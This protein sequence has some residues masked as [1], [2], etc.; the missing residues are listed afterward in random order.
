MFERRGNF[1]SV[2]EVVLK[3]TGLSEDELLCPVEEPEIYNL[4]KAVEKIKSHLSNHP[5]CMVWIVGDYDSDGINATAIMYY[6]L[7]YYGVRNVRCRIPKRFTEGYGLSDHIIE[8]IDECIRKITDDTAD[9]SNSLIITVDNGIAAADAIKLARLKGFTVIVTDHHLAPVDEKG[10]R[11]LP[12]ADVIV[13]PA[14]D[15]VT[16]YKSY[17][18][19]GLAYRLVKKLHNNAKMPQLAAFASIA[20][21]TDVVNVT[22]ANRRLVQ[23]G[24]ETVNE[25]RIL[26]GLCTLLDICEFED[27]ITETDYGFRIGPMF[28]A[29][30]RMEDEGAD[31]VL[32]L[33]TSANVASMRFKAKMLK[34]TND[35]RKEASAKQ[36]AIAENLIGDERPIVVVSNQF[37]PGIIG[38]VAGR[39]AEKYHCPAIVLSVNEDGSLKGSARTIPEIHIKEALDKCS[40]TLDGYGGH[41]GAAGLSL[42][43]E[44]LE[45]FKSQFKKACGPIPESSAGKNYDLDISMEQ[46]PF[47][48]ND[49]KVYAPYGEGNPRP[50]FHM[51]L[52]LKE[53]RV[54]NG[55]DSFSAKSGENLK[56]LGF[57]LNRK[58]VDLKKP[59]RID[60]IGFLS[61]SWYK[62]EMSY[63]FELL[64][65]EPA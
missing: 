64:A 14:A 57:G 36:C 17:C 54:V 21:I 31:D 26:P 30:S 47:V 39:L 13:D 11:I 28:N 3:N 42:Q 59:K 4:D 45:E 8:E 19:A 58:Y 29:A 33:L 44:N 9:K 1:T 55:E 24:L 65:F 41:A 49:L 6:G 48:V 22:G 12:P 46:L 50:V 23:L 53:Y 32:D 60:A 62:G 61:E 63:Q 7:R 34:E 16:E 10:N 2:K 52:D 20:T 5:D 15:D 37:T 40:D 25:R 56:I 18:G 38:I 35:A 27:H 43:A 51:I